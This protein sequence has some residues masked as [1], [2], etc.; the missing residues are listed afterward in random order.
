MLDQ[1]NVVYCKSSV[2]KLLRELHLYYYKPQLRDYRRP[3]NAEVELEQKIAATLDALRIKGIELKDCV[4]G[5]LDESSFQNY[6]NSARLWSC[7]PNVIKRVN[8]KKDRL[9]TCGFYTLNG[10]DVVLELS[11]SKVPSIKEALLQIRQANSENKA[12]IVILD[13]HTAHCCKEVLKYAHSLGICL[14]G[15]PSYSPDL[16]PIERIWKSIKRLI[17]Q[18]GFIENKERLKHI[19]FDA[20]EKLS[21]ELSFANSWIDRFLNGHEILQAVSA[22]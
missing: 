1:F 2:W 10:N 4:I 15:L 3:E 18:T 12:V 16:N 13:N 8:T 19:A 7:F 17:S 14:I 6:H 21:K 9:N 11:D 22:N 5:F 20:F